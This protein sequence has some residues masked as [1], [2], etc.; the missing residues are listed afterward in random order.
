M[1]LS[2]LLPLL[3]L[4]SCASHPPFRKLEDDLGY[5]VKE[6]PVPEILD[7]DVRLPPGTKPET[8]DDYLARAAGEECAARHF[9]YFDYGPTRAGGAR[10]FCYAHDVASHLG[11]TID[12]KVAAG[13]SPVLRVADTEMGKFS[14][15]RPWD[16]IRKVAGREVHDLAELKESLYLAGKKGSKRVTVVVERSEIPLTLE[17]PL[18]EGAEPLLTPEKLEALRAKVP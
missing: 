4:A 11:A 3:L 8:R 16:V 12:R 1:K 10:A 5:T 9:P 13:S 15:L 6:T 7:L 14:P 2:A 18:L 17:S